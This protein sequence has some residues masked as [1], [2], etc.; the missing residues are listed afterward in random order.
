[1]LKDRKDDQKKSCMLQL[2]YKSQGKGVCSYTAQITFPVA[3]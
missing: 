1:M 3:I 2:L